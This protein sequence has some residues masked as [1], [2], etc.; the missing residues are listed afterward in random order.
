MKCIYSTSQISKLNLILYT[1]SVTGLVASLFLIQANILYI[2]IKD[3]ASHT[4][5]IISHQVYQSCE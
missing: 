2:F 3:V 5:L 1:F 4:I